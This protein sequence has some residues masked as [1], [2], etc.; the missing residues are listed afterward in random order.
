MN[1][2]LKL[3]STG[4]AQQSTKSRYLGFCIKMYFIKIRYKLFYKTLTKKAIQF[5]C[6]G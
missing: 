2:H 5:S 6:G 1:M 4:K 3:K